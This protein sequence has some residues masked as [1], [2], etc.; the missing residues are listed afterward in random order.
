MSSEKVETPK[1][2]NCPLDLD[3]EFVASIIRGIED[4]KTGRGKSFN[5]IEEVMRY[6]DSL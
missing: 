6:L 3:D 2:E 5:S 4:Y 1:A